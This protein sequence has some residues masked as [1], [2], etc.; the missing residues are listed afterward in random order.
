MDPD[1]SV[2]LDNQC[3]HH[4][5]HST[6]DVGGAIYS[7]CTSR[8]EWTTPVLFKHGQRWRWRDVPG[9]NSTTDLNGCII[10]GN[11]CC[12]KTAVQSDSYDGASGQIMVVSST[13][14]RQPTMAEPPTSERAAST[15][16]VAPSTTASLTSMAEPSSTALREMELTTTATCPSPTAI[17][18]RTVAAHGSAIC[19]YQ[20]DPNID[21][22]ITSCS[23]TDNTPSGTWFDSMEGLWPSCSAIRSRGT[24]RTTMPPSSTIA[25]EASATIMDCTR[26]G[27]ITSGQRE[28]RV[29]RTTMALTTLAIG[30]TVHATTAR[31]PSVAP[32]PILATTASSSSVM[33]MPMAFDDCIRHAIQMAQTQ[34][35]IR[36]ACS[37]PWTTPPGHYHP[38]EGAYTASRRAAV[39]DTGGKEITIVR[40]TWD[41]LAFEHHRW[42]GQGNQGRQW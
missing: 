13:Q 6:I 33:G 7:N 32:G 34:D 3:Q 8:G 40:A 9:G 5:E 31:T 23:F 11:S 41:R 15:S 36:A 39:L 2:L 12:R 27:T 35:V 18:T 10:S 42:R 1:S 25:D 19:Q 14:T 26:N 28:V 30:S 17:S 4:L 29:C 38:G 21:M 20:N 16:P 37:R 22:S 24:P